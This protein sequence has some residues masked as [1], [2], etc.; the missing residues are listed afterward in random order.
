[1]RG[2]FAAQERE[3]MIAEFRIR[4]AR[5]LRSQPE[6]LGLANF[7]LA[8]LAFGWRQ[9]QCVITDEARSRIGDGAATQQCGIICQRRARYQQQEK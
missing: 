4:S 7:V 6:L 5:A 2:P 3:P 8:R 9:N 1:M